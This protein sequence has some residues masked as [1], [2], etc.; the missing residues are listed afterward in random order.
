MFDTVGTM[1]SQL[2]RALFA[3]T[4][5]V[6]QLLLFR[7]LRR[8]IKKQ[9]LGFPTCANLL[10][11]TMKNMRLDSEYAIYN[12]FLFRLK[13][14]LVQFV[15]DGSKCD[16][17]IFDVWSKM[18]SSNQGWPKAGPTRTGEGGERSGKS[19]RK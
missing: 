2:M 6:F 9:K 8:L 13:V 10:T 11:K 4:R 18:P 5:D 12:S 1:A 19:G 17:T 14:L 7:N 3:D 15:H 16:S